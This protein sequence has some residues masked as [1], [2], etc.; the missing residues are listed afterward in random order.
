[1]LLSSSFALS[2]DPIR[3]CVGG[4]PHEDNH[5]I[6]NDFQSLPL[7]WGSFTGSHPLPL[8][9]T[10]WREVWILWSGALG[11]ALT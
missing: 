5:M 1:M 4:E 2:I 6:T 3:H 8:Q 7:A 11:T 10:T 9:V